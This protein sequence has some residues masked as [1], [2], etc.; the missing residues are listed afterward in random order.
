MK[1]GNSHIK[2]FNN[3]KTIFVFGLIVLFACNQDNHTESILMRYTS[4]N[5]GEQKIYNYRL[6][7]IVYDKILTYNYSDKQDGIKYSL[8]FDNENNSISIVEN[9]IKSTTILLG[10]KHINFNDRDINVSCYRVDNPDHL[11]E[12]QT[13]YFNKEYGLIISDFSSGLNEYIKTKEKSANIEKVLEMIKNDSD[14]MNLDIEYILK[15][16]P[17]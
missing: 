14:F 17:N 7:T 16:L 12:K 6:E 2:L 10:T 9:D 3:L 4:K 11:G 5:N 1:S 8:I 15:N 13:I